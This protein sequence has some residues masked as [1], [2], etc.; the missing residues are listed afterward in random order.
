[1]GQMIYVDDMT[2]CAAIAMKLSSRGLWLRC[3]SWCR[4]DL[5]DGGMGDVHHI[6]LHK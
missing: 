5:S 1:M 2:H 6:G 4:T 3:C